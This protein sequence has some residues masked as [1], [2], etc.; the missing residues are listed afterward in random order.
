MISV[1]TTLPGK[2]VGLSLTPAHVPTHGA[3][4]ASA[5]KPIPSAV[6]GAPGRKAIRGEKLVIFVPLFEPPRRATGLTLARDTEARTS[7]TATG[8]FAGRQLR[9]PH[10]AGGACQYAIDSSASAKT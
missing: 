3:G 9:Q 2:A 5:W 1:S 6:I 4:A 10:R 7:R 8:E